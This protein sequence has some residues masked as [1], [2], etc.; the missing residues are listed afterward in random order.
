M[1]RKIRNYYRRLL[2]KIGILKLKP[3]AEIKRLLDQ[4][5]QVE[6][7]QE[8]EHKMLI[9]LFPND[10]WYRCTTCQQ[11]WIITE[12][13]QIKADKMP[14]LIKKLQQVSKSKPKNKKITPL[15]EFHNK[16]K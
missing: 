7:Q 4:A 11:V 12:A 10:V 14:F 2:V 3:E 5:I 9:A 13:M 6:E 1:K 8:C 15:D 16:L